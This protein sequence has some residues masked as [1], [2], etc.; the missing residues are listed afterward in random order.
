MK[1]LVQLEQRIL[2]ELNEVQEIQ[3]KLV[4]SR[5]V[6]N[7]DYSD[8]QAVFL[9]DQG[10]FGDHVQKS[11]SSAQTKGLQ[12]TKF[13][14]RLSTMQTDCSQLTES[15]ISLISRDKNSFKPSMHILSGSETLSNQTEDTQLEVLEPRLPGKG[16]KNKAFVQRSPIGQ[17]TAEKRRWSL[18]EYEDPDDRSLSKNA[19]ASK[20]VSRQKKNQGSLE[21][22]T[23]K[24]RNRGRRNDIPINILVADYNKENYGY[25]NHATPSKSAR[26]LVQ[27]RSNTPNNRSLM[28]S[29]K[30]ENPESEFSFRPQ[31][32][33][34]S[35]RIAENLVGW[36]DSEPIR[37]REA[38]HGS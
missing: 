22:S 34:K 20:D 35:M 23:S 8:P 14:K 29:K 37:V 1:A 13:M 26:K 11:T 4:N 21:T 25:L 24:S 18:L 12:K 36:L 10:F 3:N 9:K 17:K 27:L 19:R 7:L 32:S 31:L 5:M 6:K 38:N 2:A 30:K 28:N 16:G 15:Q 33:A